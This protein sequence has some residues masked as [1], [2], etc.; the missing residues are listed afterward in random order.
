M[1]KYLT[2]EL[3]SSTD[4]YKK[5]LKIL[6]VW[7]K[8]SFDFCADLIASSGYDSHL[9]ESIAEVLKTT[10]ILNFS[11]LIQNKSQLISATHLLPHTE[12][13]VLYIREY[14]AIMSREILSDL[15]DSIA[16]HFTGELY[17]EF[18]TS[19]LTFTPIDQFLI[20]IKTAR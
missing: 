15:A 1:V 4:Q 12:P 8:P 11:W 19:M 3:Q 13:N 20:K 14:G 18:R 16:R 2:L 7:L 17:I 10:K 6:F 9:I 5:Y